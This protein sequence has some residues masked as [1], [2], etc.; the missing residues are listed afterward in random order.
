LEGYA[1]KAWEIFDQLKSE[2]ARLKAVKEQ[3][4]I[5]S[6]EFGWEEAGHAWSKNGRVFNS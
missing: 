5:R 4:M 3:I 1:T 2:S 6:K